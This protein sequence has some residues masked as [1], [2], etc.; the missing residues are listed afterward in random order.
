MNLLSCVRLFVIPL[1]VAYQAPMSVGILQARILEWAAISFSR[2]S[3][4]P[5]DWTKVW[6]I[7]L[8]MDS[9]PAELS[10]SPR[11]LEWIAYPFSRVSSWP[12]KLDQGLLHWR[13]IIY[14]LSYQG[15]P[16]LRV[17]VCVY[18][19]IYIYIH[20]HIKFYLKSKRNNKAPLSLTP[21]CVFIFDTFHP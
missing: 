4:Q 18:I 17:C 1:T 16:H 14:Q 6:C 2:G 12:K 20:T 15:S 11:I 10:G 7:A 21:S 13:W 9:L 3:S 8:Q 19:Y 5:R